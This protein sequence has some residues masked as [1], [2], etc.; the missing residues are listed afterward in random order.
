MTNPMTFD[1][2]LSTL[3]H[4]FLQVFSRVLSTY[5]FKVTIRVTS[6]KKPGFDI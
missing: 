5:L 4:N 3:S 6:K 1:E 2:N